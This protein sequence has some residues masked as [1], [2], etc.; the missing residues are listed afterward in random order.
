MHALQYDVYMVLQHEND[1][2]MLRKKTVDQTPAFLSPAVPRISSQRQLPL[3]ERCSTT[4][5]QS[6]S[7]TFYDRST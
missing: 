4:S 3:T 5:Q 7:R 2:D 6:R 1:D